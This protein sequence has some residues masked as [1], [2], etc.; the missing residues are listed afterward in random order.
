MSETN[1]NLT[2]S[3]IAIASEM[4]RFQR[5]FAKAISKLD[6]EERNKYNSQFAWFSKKVIK[7]IDDAGLRIV[8]ID[9]QLYDPGMAVTPLNIE[10][11]ETDDVLYVVQTMEQIIMQENTVVK[12]GTVLLGRKEI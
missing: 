4:F 11:F 5:V 2:D 6:I 7:A 3:I 10:D 8:N 12:T 9:G 1:K